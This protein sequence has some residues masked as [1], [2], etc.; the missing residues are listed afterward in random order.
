MN[1][2]N[3][4]KMQ[5]RQRTKREF[6]SKG[7]DWEKEMIK[8]KTKRVRIFAR[9]SGEPSMEKYGPHW[10]DYVLTPIL[11]KKG[12][13]GVTGAYYLSMLQEHLSNIC[14][15]NPIYMQ[16]NSLVHTNGPVQEFV[17][18]NRA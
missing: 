13:G 17:G 11:L 9:V 18:R 5:A 10:W 12:G 3:V 16:D 8:P 1:A 4:R 14:I 2:P 15:I 7:E 6:R